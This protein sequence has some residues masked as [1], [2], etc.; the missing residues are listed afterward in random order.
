MLRFRQ[1]S[2]N[3]PNLKFIGLYNWKVIRVHVQQSCSVLKR[4]P[5]KSLF[6]ITKGRFPPTTQIWHSYNRSVG[7]TV[8]ALELQLSETYFTLQYNYNEKLNL[9]FVLQM[10]LI[11]GVLN[12]YIRKHFHYLLLFNSHAE[13]CDCFSK[14]SRTIFLSG[15]DKG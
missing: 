4:E 12:N 8:C 7:F 1:N 14:N 3:I 15:S 5:N 11:F 10:W 6:R 13:S 2:G 9:Q